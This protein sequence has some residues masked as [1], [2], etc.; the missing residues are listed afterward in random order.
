MP[1]I[2]KGPSDNHTAW[3]LIE[4]RNLEYKLDVN[5]DIWAQHGGTRESARSK[6]MPVLPCPGW[7]DWKE[8]LPWVWVARQLNL[9]DPARGNPSQIFSGCSSEKIAGSSASS[10]LLNSAPCHCYESA[11]ADLRG[12]SNMALFGF[13]AEKCWFV[14]RIHP[15]RHSALRKG[16][17]RGVDGTLK[18]KNK[19]KRKI[20][21][22]YLCAGLHL[23]MSSWCQ[24][25]K[26]HLL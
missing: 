15:G 17:S 22:L 24:S 9:W 25:E 13:L 3:E 5:S 8:G 1:F 6:E 19:K 18:K 11:K 4:C 2:R 12:G 26:L 14:C 20:G 23:S 10:L 7:G 16:F 21:W